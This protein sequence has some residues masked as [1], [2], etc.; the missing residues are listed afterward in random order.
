MGGKQEHVAIMDR[1]VA[2]GV[3]SD[4][5]PAATFTCNE[6][7]AQV[8]V[9]MWRVLRAGARP[10][11]HAAWAHLGGVPLDERALPRGIEAILPEKPAHK[12]A[13]GAVPAAPAA[14]EVAVAPAAGTHG[15]AA[16]GAA[17]APAAPV[18]PAAGAPHGAAVRAELEVAGAKAG[19]RAGA[20]AAA[21]EAG[22]PEAPVL[23]PPSLQ[24]AAA[25]AE[26]GQEGQEGEGED[27]EEEEM[28]EAAEVAF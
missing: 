23:P 5:E 2:L 19:A 26:E 16:A 15:A 6:P 4:D 17:P 14:P 3:F 13:A 21:P 20:P 9:N 1:G 27:E 8:G 7:A 22:G 18:A 11:A 25:E 10:Q 24:G 12:V 28:V